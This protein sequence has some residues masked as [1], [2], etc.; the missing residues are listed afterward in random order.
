[1]AE[2]NGKT[3]TIPKWFITTLSTICGLAVPWAIW[4]TV[5][6]KVMSRQLNE[7]HPIEMQRRMDK[8]E[9]RMGL[10]EGQLKLMNQSLDLLMAKD[11]T[12][13]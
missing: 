4:T 5:E 8:V 13:K 3:V 10:I 6:L 1:M 11:S 7:I 2:S 12:P 9:L